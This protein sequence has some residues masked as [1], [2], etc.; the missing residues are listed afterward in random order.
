MSPWGPQGTGV[1]ALSGRDL[2]P[3]HSLG[4][5]AA[6]S[7]SQ[8]RGH[9][10]PRRRGQSLSSPGPRPGLSVP[11]TFAFFSSAPSF[12]GLLCPPLPRRA[13]TAQPAREWP[14]LSH[15]SG[16]HQSLRAAWR[17]CLR[18]PN[19]EVLSESNAEVLVVAQ[20]LTN[21]TSIH[22]DVGSTPGPAQRVKDLPLP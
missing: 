19:Q 11:I 5:S 6:L 1:G 18:E 17:I 13:G 14:R 2:S 3:I 22:E 21:P 10:L 4:P 7:P 15:Q 12:E 8:G 16:Q 9:C 20:Q